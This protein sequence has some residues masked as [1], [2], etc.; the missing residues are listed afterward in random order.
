MI[1]NMKIIEECFAIHKDR[2]SAETQFENAY[3]NI[4]LAFFPEGGNIYRGCKV[5]YQ[6]RNSIEIYLWTCNTVIM[7]KF[8]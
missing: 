5:G 3:R 6:Y 4:I 8:G 1:W 2:D 7:E